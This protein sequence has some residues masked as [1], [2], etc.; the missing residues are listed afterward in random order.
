MNVSLSIKA[1]HIIRLHL[2][3]IKLQNKNHKSSQTAR[4]FYTAGN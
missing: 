2:N 1:D 3:I 4:H